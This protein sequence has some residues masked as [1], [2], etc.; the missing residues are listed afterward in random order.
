MLQ[1]RASTL[2]KQGYSLAQDLTHVF[3]KK[4]FHLGLTVTSTTDPAS[5]NVQSVQDHLFPITD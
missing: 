2:K 4:N 1:T 3:S 5:T